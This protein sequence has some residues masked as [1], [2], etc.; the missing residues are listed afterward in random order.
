MR[1]IPGDFNQQIFIH[2]TGNSPYPENTNFETCAPGMLKLYT[3]GGLL[4]SKKC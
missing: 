4:T 1:Q 2:E 3:F